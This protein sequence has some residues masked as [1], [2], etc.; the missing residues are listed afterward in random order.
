MITGPSFGNPGPQSAAD[1]THGPSASE[2]PCV[3]ETCST[4]LSSRLAKRATAAVFSTGRQRSLL[5]KRDRPRWPAAGDRSLARTE[6]GVRGQGPPRL[7][8]SQ[9]R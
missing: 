4:V 7:R 2:G 8:G 9:V 1:S 3:G 5:P 6:A